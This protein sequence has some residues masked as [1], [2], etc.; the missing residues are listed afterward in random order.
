MLCPGKASNAYRLYSV[1]S[2]PVHFSFFVLNL[3]LLYYN[4]LV[5]TDI[6]LY[7]TSFDY[8]YPPFTQLTVMASVPLLR[9]SRFLSDVNTIPRF[10]RPELS[11]PRRLLCFVA[12]SWF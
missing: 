2:I 8:V 1:S 7:E 6:A 9:R 12:S 3:H 4:C 5:M 10:L 11:L